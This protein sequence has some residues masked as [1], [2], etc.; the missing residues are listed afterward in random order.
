MRSALRAGLDA[1]GARRRRLVSA[2][3]AVAADRQKVLEIV[4]EASGLKVWYMGE[5]FR[6]P[7]EGGG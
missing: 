2:Q 6:M 4:R 7:R 3:P 5:S 1:L